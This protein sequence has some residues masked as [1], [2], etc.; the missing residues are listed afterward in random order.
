MENQE[1]VTPA[2]FC[3]VGEQTFGIRWQDGHESSYPCYWLRINCPCAACVDELTGTR[4][5][6]PDLVPTD[7]HPMRVQSVGRYA[8]QIR[9]SDEHSTGI[10]TFDFLR[11]HCPCHKCN[12]RS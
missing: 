11:A 7:V 12:R 9:W 5:V 10:Y 4:R 8:I 3:Q 1:R 2:E 6:R